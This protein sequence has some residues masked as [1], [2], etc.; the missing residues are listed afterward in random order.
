V[1]ERNAVFGTFQL[2]D[3]FP[4]TD[5][6]SAVRVVLFR[7]GMTINRTRL[8]QATLDRTRLQSLS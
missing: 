2:H 6:R 4:L 5:E 1:V 8:H 3:V 7:D